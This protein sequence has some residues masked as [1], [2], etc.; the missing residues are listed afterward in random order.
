MR[1]DA[2]LAAM[3][4]M[5]LPEDAGEVTMRADGRF[6]GAVLAIEVSNDGVMFAPAAAPTRALVNSAWR[7]TLRCSGPM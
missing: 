3:G 5:R 4:T 7:C 2:P 6:D 1:N